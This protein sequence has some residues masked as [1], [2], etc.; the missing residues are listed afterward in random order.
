MATN[1]PKLKAKRTGTVMLANSVETISTG[2]GLL[3][4]PLWHQKLG[5]IVADATVGGVWRIAHGAVPEVIIPHRRGI[6]GLALHANGSVV[7]GGRRLALTWPGA[8]GQD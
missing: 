7:T 3:E 1:D 6:G 2:H 8:D 4:G 5:L